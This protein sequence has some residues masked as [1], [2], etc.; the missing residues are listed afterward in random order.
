MS[1]YGSNFVDE[2]NDD[3][4]AILSDIAHLE[5]VY[6]LDVVNA[7]GDVTAH[8]VTDNGITTHAPAK[9]IRRMWR[10]ELGPFITKH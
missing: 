6:E 5:S 4:D 8:E 3:E 1:D 2:D 7:A 10:W 9:F